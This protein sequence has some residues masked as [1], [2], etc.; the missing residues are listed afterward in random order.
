MQDRRQAN[1]RH[2]GQRRAIKRCLERTETDPCCGPQ[3]GKS[4]C[5]AIDDNALS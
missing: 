5:L 3:V 1:W 4:D 2:E